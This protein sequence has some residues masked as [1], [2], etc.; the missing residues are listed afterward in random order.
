M[1][2]FLNR[3]K[4]TYTCGNDIS[5]S[6]RNLEAPDTNTWKPNLVVSTST[7]D[8]EKKRETHQF[9]LD[10]K[11]EYNEFMRRKREFNENSCKVYA[12]LWARC[13][14]DMQENKEY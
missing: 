14:K 12:E 3:I 9:E 6:L 8:D 2:F 5:E 10:Y 11:A 1:N 7:D 4:R 13:N